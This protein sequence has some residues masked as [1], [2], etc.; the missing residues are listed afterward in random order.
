MSDSMVTPSDQVREV[1]RQRIKRLAG[2]KNESYVKATLAKLRRG[3]GKK[4]GELFELLEFTVGGLPPELQ[5]KGR[6]DATREEAAAYTA[7]TLFA[8][9]QQGKDIARECVSKDGRR[10]GLAVG[11][12]AQGADEE[13]IKRRFN[14]AATADT[15]GEFANH[16]RGLVQLLKAER[17][18]LDYPALAE[19]L[20]WFQDAD[21]RDQV[22]LGWGQDFYRR[23]GSRQQDAGQTYTKEDED[24]GSQE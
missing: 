17:L 10:L 16:L 6:A 1:V 15:P 12:L 14:A 7:L 13:R 23:I 24:D 11:D 18:T 19:D 21:R 4:P 9:H 5:A 3:I 22:R 2:S 8:L 20:Y